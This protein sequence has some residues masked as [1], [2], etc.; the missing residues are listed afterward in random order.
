MFG[1]VQRT[2][3]ERLANTLCTVTGNAS[4]DA[5]TNSIFGVTFTLTAGE[6]A[7]QSS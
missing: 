4:I 1:T 3:A 5:Q 7:L 6:R 2:L